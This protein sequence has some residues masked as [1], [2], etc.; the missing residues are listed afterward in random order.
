MPTDETLTSLVQGAFL[1][2]QRLSAQPL[3]LSV[4]EN[5]VTLEGSVQTYRRKLAAQEIAASFDGVR[6]VI[7]NLT[8]EPPDQM[9]D[10]E[11]AASVRA[12]LDSNADVAKEVITVC[13]N[14]RVA[15]LAGAVG[16]QWEAIVAEDVARGVRGVRDV[17]NLLLVDP[18]EQ[19]EDQAMCRKI[20]EALRDTRG[21]KQARISAT[22]SNNLVVLSG[23]VE[24]LWQKES[25]ESAV[26][27]LGLF[28]IRNAILVTGS[29]NG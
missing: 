12:A 20:E 24:Q 14:G 6:G 2:D 19:L 10:D 17:Q 7:N 25:A 3:K 5:I 21:L 28:R 16:N 8:V 9:S 11:I 26:E 23:K 18:A 29:I 1:N 15:S 13:V 22:V 4:A 27:R